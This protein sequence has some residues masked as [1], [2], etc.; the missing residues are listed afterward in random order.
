MYLLLLVLGYSSSVTEQKFP[1]PFYISIIFFIFLFSVWEKDMIILL[2]FCT[3][4]GSLY[5]LAKNAYSSCLLVD[6]VLK[7]IL[8]TAASSATILSKDALVGLK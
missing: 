2:T 5:P 8:S 3:V 7:E 6:A 1:A 4:C